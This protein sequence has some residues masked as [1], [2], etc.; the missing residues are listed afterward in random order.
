[1]D[2]VINLRKNNRFSLALTLAN[3][4]KK[5]LEEINTKE[6]ITIEKKVV[7]Y[8]LIKKFEILL[9]EKERAESGKNMMKTEMVEESK[10]KGE[11]MNIE[12]NVGSLPYIQIR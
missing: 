8:H 9:A 10:E 6:N 2:T 3:E 11:K 5:I 1:M 7:V 12:I 4:F